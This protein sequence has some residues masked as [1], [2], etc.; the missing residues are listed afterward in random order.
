M[1]GWG[2]RRIFA[3]RASD[4]LGSA[5]AQVSLHM[6]LRAWTSRRRGQD[7]TLTVCSARWLGRP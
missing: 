2:Y 7:A 3:W 6:G 1:G 5:L 4:P